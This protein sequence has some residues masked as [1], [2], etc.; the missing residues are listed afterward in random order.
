MIFREK[1]R[2]R[3]LGAVWSE[4]YNGIIFGIKIKIF[5]FWNQIFI[6]N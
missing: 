2:G 5:E 4:L 6:K 3:S 1:K